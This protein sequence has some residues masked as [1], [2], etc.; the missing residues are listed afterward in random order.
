MPTISQLPLAGSI[1]PS[2]EV[3]ISQAG[4][5]RSAS[6]G[7]LL[8]SVQP[9]IVVDSRSLLGRQ[10]LG[11]GGPEQIDI[12]TGINLSGGTLVADGLDHATFPSTSILSIQSDLV[13]SNQGNPMLM[14]AALLRGLFAA[15][16]NVA[17]DQNG[18]ISATGISTDVGSNTSLSSIAALQVITALASQDLIP[19]TRSGAEVAISYANFLDGITIDQ[20]QPAAAAGDSDT[21]WVAQGSNVMASQT[22][23]A[24]W[25]WIANKLPTYKCPVVEITTN[26][27]LDTTVHNGRLLICSQPVTLTPLTGNMGSGFQCTV[28]NASTGNLTL[29]SGF[30]SS[31][32]S[33]VLSPWQSAT[34]SCAIYSSG[35]IAFAAMPTTAAAASPPGQITALANSGLTSST[36]MV[37]WQ[38]PSTG[39]AVSSYL[40]QYRLTGT[41]SWTSSASVAGATTYQI[42]ALQAATSYDVVVQAQNAAGAGA[43]SSVLTVMTSS[44]A[45]TTV[46]FQVSGLAASPTS[47]TA[48]QLSWSAQ[49]GSSAATSFTVQYR[50]TGSTGWTSSVTG[51]S[52]TGTAITGIQ[53]S[54]SYDFEVIGVNTA[55]TGTASS[56]V[57]AVTLTASQSVT[58]ITWKLLPSGTYTHGTGTVG[59]NAQISPAS[60]PVQFGFSLSASTPPITWIAALFINSNLWG[61][62][63]PT[64]A[65]A[66]NWYVWGE[67][68]DGSARTVS[69]TPFTVQ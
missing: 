67:G 21:T 12:G 61:F 64:P 66:G 45:Q 8:S 2:D 55:G 54:T 34:L 44:S 63:M 6:V 59:I 17:I 65:T 11:S 26:T 36:I 25:I 29:G 52:G 15:G 22:F 16:Q 42:T 50:L 46:P 19:V 37:S 49:T 31:S 56:I 28:I 47:A 53:P 58:S 4:A 33:L 9:A 3:P 69:P 27:N 41:T 62:Y 40:V 13:I 38:A 18:V 60:S 7:A 30:L 20:A 68:L 35:T 1:S 5:A 43:A 24:I 51:I 14:P 39:G 57:T 23:R 48:I 32:G 10:S